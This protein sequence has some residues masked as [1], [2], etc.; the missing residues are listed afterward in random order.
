[1]LKLNE[2]NRLTYSELQDYKENSGITELQY[3]IIKM[4][5]YDSGNP[6]VV[7]I[8][9]KLNISHK[10]YN[11]ELKKAIQQIHRYEKIKK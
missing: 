6:T 5:H 1:M 11:R 8:C 7:A 3:Q 4:R 9:L 2:T 10:K